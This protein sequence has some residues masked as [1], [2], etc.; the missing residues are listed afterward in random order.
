MPPASLLLAYIHFHRWALVL[1]LDLFGIAE[2]APKLGVMHKVAQGTSDF[3]ALKWLLA[4]DDVA[5]SV[6]NG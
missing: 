4:A 6:G 1:A 2:S 5:K 3:A